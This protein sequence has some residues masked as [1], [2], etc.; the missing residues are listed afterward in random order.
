MQSRRLTQISGMLLAMTLG[1]ACGPGMT[2]TDGGTEG[3]VP[4]DTRVTEGGTEDG[5]DGSTTPVVMSIQVTPMTA[6]VGVGGMT[7]FT[8]TATLSNM[9]TQDVT[10]MATWASSDPTKATID[11]T[12]QATGVANG[13]TMIT[14]TFGGMTSAAAT[15]TVAAPMVTSIALNPDR[16]SVV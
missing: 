16:K 9:M 12:G 7:R 3:G 5:G 11:M 10:T 13:P 1:V 15:L 2:T 6:M 14:A 4:T 8:A